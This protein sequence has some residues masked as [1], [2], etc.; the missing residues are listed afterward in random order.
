MI[1]ITLNFVSNA[2]FITV[3]VV[4][5]NIIVYGWLQIFQTKLEHNMYVSKYHCKLGL[6]HAGNFRHA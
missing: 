1:I 3:D 6:L 5:H 4:M 2:L